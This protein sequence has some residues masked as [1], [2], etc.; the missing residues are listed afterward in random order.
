MLV[1][2]WERY[3]TLHYNAPTLKI[4][5]TIT[6]KLSRL[7][8]WPVAAN[9]TGQYYPHFYN[10]IYLHTDLKDKSKRNCHIV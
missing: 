1:K 9:T 8:D 3:C 5:N 2:K 4:N 10:F 7:K 6:I